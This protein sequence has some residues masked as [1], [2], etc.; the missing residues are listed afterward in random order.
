MPEARYGSSL[1]LVVRFPVARFDLLQVIYNVR[2][3]RLDTPNILE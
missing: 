1:G 3:E 2:G